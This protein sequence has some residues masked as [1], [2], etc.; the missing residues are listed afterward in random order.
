MR[1]EMCVEFFHVKFFCMYM[2]AEVLDRAACTCMQKFLIVLNFYMS[3]F[4]ACTYI[5]SGVGC[6]SSSSKILEYLALMGK[7]KTLKRE[8]WVKRGVN[9]PESDSDHMHR[10]ALIAM[11]IP[12]EAN[13]DR[14][15]CIRMGLVHDVCE[16]IAGD[17]TPVCGVSKE[18]KHALERSAM[19]EIFRVLGG[20]TVAAEL[21]NLWE[22]YE[23]GV[24]PESIYVKDIDKFEM[25]VQ[26][27]EYEQVQP[28]LNLEEFFNSTREYF[29]TDFFRNLDSQLR[30]RR[31]ARRNNV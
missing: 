23:A 5:R 13:V 19:N 26:A 18:A 25:I 9:M 29:K 14:D 30:K 4:S 8:G 3:N 11:L 6:M 24:T 27:D 15:K 20:G 12:V 21:L 16:C 22:E 7:L 2:Y 31:S 17:I 1:Q 28:G 10:V